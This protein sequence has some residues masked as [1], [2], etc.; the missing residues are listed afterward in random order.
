MMQKK[1][2]KKTDF[3]CV[4][5]RVTVFG[6]NGGTERCDEQVTKRT[7][8]VQDWDM[9]FG[10]S[11][12]KHTN[13]VG[14]W[15]PRRAQLDQ[16]WRQKIGCAMALLSRKRRKNVDAKKM[17][18][19]LLCKFPIV[20]PKTNHVFRTWIGKTCEAKPW[21]FSIRAC[22]FRKMACRRATLGTS[23]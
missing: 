21:Y 10:C 8:C 23:E 1:S 19:A 13:C 17:P 16:C 14:D 2:S 12:A 18:K 9:K 7:K 4:V 20:T 3:G 22:S 11:C 6:H 5:G 15:D